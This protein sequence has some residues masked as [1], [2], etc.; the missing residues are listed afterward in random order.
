MVV[1]VVGAIA[2]GVGGLVGDVALLRFGPGGLLSW[3]TSM[4][5]VGGVVAA[6]GTS[7]GW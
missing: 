7:L 3:V 1:V 2:G 4:V 6:M 5:V